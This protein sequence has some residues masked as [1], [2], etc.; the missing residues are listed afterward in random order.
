MTRFISL[1]T[2]PDSKRNQEYENKKVKQKFFNKTLALFKDHK[3][4]NKKI[5]LAISG[6]LDSVVLLD[7]LKELSS[8]CKLKL[9][10]VY[11]HHGLSDQKA[12]QNY[13]DKAKKLVSHLC[14]SHKLDFLCPNPP[15]SLLKSEE[16]FRNFRRSH[17]EKI[18]KQK[19][20]DAIA[21]AHNNNDLLETRLLQLIR[22]C[23]E[24]GLKA[25]QIWEHPYLRPLLNFSRQEIK[26][27][28]VQNKLQWLEDPSNKDNRYLRNWIRNKWL[29]DLENKKAGAVKSLARS[30]ESLCVSQNENLC[31]L[32]VSSQG[33]KRRLLMEMPPKEQKRTL[34]FYMRKLK[35]LN[36][37]QSHIEEILK[38]TERTEK[39][40]SIKLLKKTWTFTVKF[41]SA[42]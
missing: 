19:Q 1:K 31:F 7:L 37:G 29:T 17:F 2:Q 15:K 33:I 42:K 36:Y 6:G 32:A 16:K 34:A 26:S 11:I 24:A 40:F 38:Q 9:Y 41:I 10:P 5:I 18:L 3:I 22:G 14:Q 8:P 23:G 25:M 21:L 35:L 39:K 28:A 20:A 27:Y 4:Q 13:R 30:L 12:I